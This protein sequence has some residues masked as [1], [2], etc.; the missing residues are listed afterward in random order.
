MLVMYMFEVVMWEWCGYFL[1]F[2]YVMLVGGYV[3]VQFI[4]LV[5]LVVFICEQVYEFGWCIGFVV[6]G[7][8]VIVVFWLW[9]MMDELFSQECL[10]VIKVGWDYDFGLF[11]ELVI[12][13][14]KLLLFC[15]F[16]MLGGMVVF[17]IYSVNVFV[18]VKSV[19]GLQV[20]IVI[21]IN[22][23]GLILLM[24]LQFIGGMISDK[25]GCKLL[26]LWFGVGGFIYIY[27]FVIYFFEICLL[28]MLFL[29]VVVGYVILIGYCLINVLVKFELFFVYV[30]V[31]GVGVGYVLVNLVFGGI[32]L[33]I[34]QVFKEC[35]Q[36]LMF[37]VYV[38]VCI[39]VLLIVYVF[40]IKNKVDIYFD[41]EQ[42]FVFYGYVQLQC[43]GNIFC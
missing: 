10:I 14:W 15:F 17:Y 33:L 7:G 21:W 43:L 3:F 11:C 25:I 30:C 22:L 40:F 24:M 32:V 13:Y 23:V 39:V 19:Y 41:C 35:D 26:L 18:I 29:L 5:I 4:L 36:V 34:Y 28:I 37:I 20:M 6:G 1:L 27:V 9:C 31:F 16:V 38:I 42:G 12:Y 2:Q 8:V